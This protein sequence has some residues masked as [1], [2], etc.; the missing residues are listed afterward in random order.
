MDVTQYVPLLRTDRAV[1]YERPLRGKGALPS[2]PW[3]TN[4]WPQRTS[5]SFYWHRTVYVWQKL[6]CRAACVVVVV[7]VEKSWRACWPGTSLCVAGAERQGG[8]LLS[9]CSLAWRKEAVEVRSRK[10]EKEV[11]L[12]LSECEGD[13]RLVSSSRLS[14][15]SNVGPGSL[16]SRVIF[17]VIILS[18]EETFLCQ[19]LLLCVYCCVSAH[20]SFRNSQKILSC[21]RHVSRF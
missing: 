5:S 3:N 12:Q 19:T 20:F 15:F 17:T 16:S 2:D 14:G 7:V 10:K 18:E 4:M 21:S 6:C 1:I 13:L 11:P 9:L 8:V